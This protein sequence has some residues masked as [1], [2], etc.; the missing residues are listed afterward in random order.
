MTLKALRGAILRKL[1][2]NTRR[3]RLQLL[4]AN[5]RKG[6][7]LYA[8]GNYSESDKQ[9][10]SNVEL[11]RSF[12]P[13]SRELLY[14]LKNLGDFYHDTGNYL[15]AEGPFLEVMEI[16]EQRISEQPHQV[17]AALNDVALLFYAQGRYREAED[18]FRRLLEILEQQRPVSR[19]M[20]TCLENYAAVLRRLDR[21][22][23]SMQVRD[24]ARSIRDQ[25]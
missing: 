16:S 23:E 24:R 5:H 1:L 4:Q 2:P 11:A 17:V 3:G 9:F 13:E 20:A 14:Y 22:D 25:L 7:D 21:D 10:A 12:G 18:Y 15:S 6:V 19:P 8:E